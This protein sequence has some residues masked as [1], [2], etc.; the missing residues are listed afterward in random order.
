MPHTP[1]IS[2][3]PKIKKMLQLIKAFLTIIVQS[4]KFIMIGN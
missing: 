2:I 1:K 4:M 3:F